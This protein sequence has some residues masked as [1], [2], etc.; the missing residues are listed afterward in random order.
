MPKPLAAITGASAGIGAVFARKLAAR[1]YDLLLIARRRDRLE[2]LAA[3]LSPAI[4][5]PYAADL[6]DAAATAELASRLAAE[7]R[8]DL[9]VNNAGFGV[10]GRFYQ[11]PFEGQARMHR[12][13]IDAI[14]GL[15]H[16]V[17]PGMVARDRGG[18]INVASVAGFVRSPK[19]V[20]YCATKAWVNAFTK[21][22][23]VELRAAGSQVVVQS[24]CPGFTHSEFHDVAGMNRAAI[25]AS[26]WTTAEDVVDASLAGL[27]RRQPMSSPAGDTSCWSPSRPASPLPGGSPWKRWSRTNAANSQ[28]CN[29]RRGRRCQPAVP[30]LPRRPS[31]G[32]TRPLPFT[33]ASRPKL[34]GVS[35]TPLRVQLPAPLCPNP[36]HGASPSSLVAVSLEPG[37][38]R[39]AAAEAQP[40][41]GLTVPGRNQTREQAMRRGAAGTR[42]RRGEE[43]KE[44]ESTAATPR[45]RSEVKA[46]GHGG[47]GDSALKHGALRRNPTD[48]RF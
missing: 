43:E 7:S 35:A 14:L 23:A 5:E 6:A 38:R 44:R 12:L 2:Q 47:A 19:S 29:E 42:R 48:P 27:D 3:G 8:L 39:G 1:G 33:A 26:L 34:H 22:L 18:I 13:H 36:E 25:P 45:R 24:L 21:G 11:V 37:A 10:Q 30:P 15:T 9:L 41:K 32:R 40:R 28:S 20:S 4:A 17:L 31:P 16:A 46:R